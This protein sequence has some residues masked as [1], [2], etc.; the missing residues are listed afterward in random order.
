MMAGPL[1]KLIGFKYISNDKK[2]MIS[3]GED[4]FIQGRKFFVFFALTA[5]VTLGSRPEATF[6]RTGKES[7][8]MDGQTKKHVILLGASIGRAWNI[9]SLPER[10]R[11]DDYVFEYVDGGS[12][13]KSAK[14][15]EIL[16]R[17][18]N[19]PDA[20]F[21]KECAAYFP[22]DID[23]YKSLMEEWIRECYESGTIPIPTTIVPVTRL[24]SFKKILIDAAKG[25]KPFGYGN[26]FK[27]K[28][29]AAILEYN[30]WIKVYCQKKGLPFL[31]LEAAVRYSEKNRF[32]RENLAKA[33]GLH[34][35]GKAYN[36]LDQI[37]ISTL[38]KVNWEKKK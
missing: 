23:L 26:P 33:D 31:D 30:N 16:T 28:R 19:K 37:V 10:M 36:I 35:N 27:H 5:L 7:Q 8:A 20:V 3:S 29:N 34:I 11:T 1:A 6:G 25:R 21:L 22:G 2:R 18:E 9:S 12:F 13:D 15:R 14:L 32:L 24:H 17:R 4:N 38:K